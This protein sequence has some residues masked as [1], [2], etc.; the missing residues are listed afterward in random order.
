MHV[1]AH[2]PGVT[3]VCPADPLISQAPTAP[4]CLS[5]LLG[6]EGL[7]FLNFCQ[8]NYHQYSAH[9]SL[10]YYLNSATVDVSARLQLL[11]LC[12]QPYD[13]SAKSICI[14]LSLSLSLICSHVCSRH[15]LFFINP[16]PGQCQLP[17]VTSPISIHPDY[18]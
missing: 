7:F 2:S 15:R 11:F 18:V 17:A 1:P 4:A 16:V 9:F 5:S 8:Q 13:L 12:R 3:P 10:S 14:S 6:G